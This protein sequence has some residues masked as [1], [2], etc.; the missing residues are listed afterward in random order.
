MPEL[1]VVTG[2]PGAGKSTVARRLVDDF[3]PSALVAGDDFFGFL[4]RGA[5]APWLPEADEQNQMVLHSAAS[6]AGQLARRC[7][8]VYDGVVG[9]WHLP[10]FLAATGLPELHYV[11]LL[12]PLEQCLNRVATRVGHGFTD[13]RATEHMYGE[14]ARAEADDRHVLREPADDAETTASMVLG[15]VERRSALYGG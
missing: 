2:P 7:T 9:A 15:L 13:A 4:A 5:I 10:G 3:E 8:V 6:A 14:F 11:V 12:P 1:I